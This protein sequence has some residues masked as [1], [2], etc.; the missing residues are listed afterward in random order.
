MNHRKAK[1]QRR[2][3]ERFL[4]TRVR[5][6]PEFAQVIQGWLIMRGVHAAIE[7]RRS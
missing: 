2:R 5:W 6:T 3:V 1:R 4:S 7:R